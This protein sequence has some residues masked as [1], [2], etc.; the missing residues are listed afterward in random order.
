MNFKLSLV[1]TALFAGISVSAIVKTTQHS[2]IKTLDQI[3][4]YRS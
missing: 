4:R 1:Y 2:D 3:T